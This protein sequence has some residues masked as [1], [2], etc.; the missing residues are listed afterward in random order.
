MPLVRNF[1]AD[2][3]AREPQTNQ[4]PDEVVGLGATIQAGILSGAVK[5]LVLLDVTPLSL[6]IETFGGLMNVIIPRNSTI[7]L[8]SGEMFTTAVDNQRSMTIK[9]LQ[10]ER[11][12]ARDNWPLGQFDIEFDP[13]P[14]G[15]PRVGVQFEIDA[16][17]ILHVLARDT[18]TGH[19]KLVQMKSAVDVSDEAVENMLAESLDHAFEDVNERVWVETRL[20]SEE[21]LSAVDKA[22]AV[23][24]DR[25]SP[26]E[27]AAIDQCATK[28]RAALQSSDRQALK[29]AN[30]E[31]DAAT[32]HLAAMVLELL[33]PET[34]GSTVS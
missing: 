32:Q 1:V 6:G 20:K 22:W 16:D 4:N 5:D 18:K 17:G 28:V 21:M 19:E 26:E 27:R 8:K 2:L 34:R 10:G 15:I 24:G 31:L 11:E 12:M 9:V 13:A 30:E 7:P 14:K 25:I 23:V 33:M 29:R 3:F